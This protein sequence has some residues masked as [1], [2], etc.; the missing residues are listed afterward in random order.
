[1]RYISGGER[2]KDG[3]WGEGKEQKEDVEKWSPSKEPALNEQEKY[4]KM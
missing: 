4:N 1:M 2:G 3:R